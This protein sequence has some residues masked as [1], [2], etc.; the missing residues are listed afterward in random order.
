VIF[1]DCFQRVLG[2]PSKSIELGHCIDS[3]RRPLGGCRDPLIHDVL[4]FPPALGRA[5]LL[6]AE[7]TEMTL[8]HVKDRPGAPRHQSL[9]KMVK[10]RCDARFD[11]KLDRL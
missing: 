7:R 6:L 11:P 10:T 9:S 8:T 3:T 1:D 5:S 2:A 4:A